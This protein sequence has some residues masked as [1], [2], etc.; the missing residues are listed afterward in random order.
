MAARLHPSD[1]HSTGLDD[2]HAAAPR[3]GG[4]EEAQGGLMTRS[5]SRLGWGGI[6]AVKETAEPCAVNHADL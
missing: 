6:R 2:L 5:S 3:P 1:A 4:R